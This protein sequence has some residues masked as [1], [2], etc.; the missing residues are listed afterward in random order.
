MVCFK[1]WGG[2]D[3]SGGLCSHAGVSGLA[4]KGNLCLARLY[5]PFSQ[6]SLNFIAKNV[7]YR[8][9]FSLLNVLVLL[10]DRVCVSL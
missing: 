8:L 10:F 6:N 1:L 3:L 5:L 2:L 9:G 4:L 7:I